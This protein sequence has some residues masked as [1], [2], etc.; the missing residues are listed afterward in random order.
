[1]TAYSLWCKKA[2]A[3]IS[4][5]SPGLTFVEMN[6]RLSQ[7]WAVVSDAEKA[8]WKR[9]AEQANAKAGFQEG[10]SPGG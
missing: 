7:G 1:M 6:S 3:T 10:M 5:R 4:A 9:K 2:R 8:D